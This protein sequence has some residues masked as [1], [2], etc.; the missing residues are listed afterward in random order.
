MK[1]LSTADYACLSFI[2]FHLVLILWRYDIFPIFIDIYYHL[3]VMVGFDQAGGV[4]IHDFWEFAP[5]GRAHLYPPFLH[6][7][8]LIPYKLGADIISVGKFTSFIMYPITQLSLWFVAR[9]IF[10]RKT[11]FFGVLMLSVP[12]SFFELEAIVSASALA[13]IL[14]LW[15]YYFIYKKKTMAATV[16]MAFSLYTHLSLPH[17]IAGSLILWAAIDKSQRKRIAKVIFVSYILYLPWLLNIL[18]NLDAMSSLSFVQMDE[19]DLIL[20]PIALLGIIVSLFKV[21]DD[22]RKYFLPV[23]LLLAML[24]IYYSYTSRFWGHSRLPLALLAGIFVSQ[25]CKIVHKRFKIN[26][27]AVGIFFAVV[28]L[29]VSMTQNPIYISNPRYE[30]I[31]NKDTITEI[32]LPGGFFPSSRNSLLPDIFYIAFQIREKTAPDDIVFVKDGRTACLIT[33]LTGRATT[34]GMFHEVKPEEEKI[35]GKAKAFLRPSGEPRFQK[36][37]PDVY[38]IKTKNWILTIKKDDIGVIK[39]SK[40]PVSF[41]YYAAFALIFLGFFLVFL[42]IARGIRIGNKFV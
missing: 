1:K 6:L 25:L 39:R 35:W 23:A 27:R 12:W 19:I 32:L 11:A 7:L 16:F 29:F 18:F 42:D 5:A 4:V 9:E 33:S 13:S 40:L 15:T 37:P 14:A 8:M 31:V 24:P 36:A 34:N 30:E 10:S 3:S 41:S 28:I 2:A 26:K 17:L 21:K 38:E 20:L 22:Q